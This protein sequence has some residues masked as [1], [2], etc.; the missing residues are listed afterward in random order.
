[1]RLPILDRLDA[2]V[3]RSDGVP[4]FAEEL[5][6]TVAETQAEIAPSGEVPTL[7]IPE[8]LQDSLMA[9]LDALGPVKE[10]AQLCAVLGREFDYP[11][12]LQVSPLTEEALQAALQVALREELFY[13]RGTPPDASYHFRHALIRDA[14]YQSL[15]RSQRQRYHLHIANTMRER[16]PAIVEHQP[17][18]VARHLTEGGD[19]EQAL[20]LWR[21]SGRLAAERSS[22]AEAEA[23]LRA[24]IALLPELSSVPPTL[25]LELY[26]DLAGSVVAVHGLGS[27]EMGAAVR[28]LMELV[29]A[30][31]DSFA[32]NRASAYEVSRGDLAKALDLAQRAQ[33]SAERLGSEA[34]LHQSLNNQSA[35]LVFMSRFAEV[36]ELHRQLRPFDLHAERQRSV[37][38]GT[39]TPLMAG[40]YTA[41][42]L[43]FL[44]R[45]AEAMALSGETV[46][47][48]RELRHPHTL[49]QVAAFA[50]VLRRCLRQF[51]ACVSLAEES[52]HVARENGFPMW[53]GVAGL[54]AAHARTMLGDPQ[55]GAFTEAM[56]GSAR[57][58]NRA[59]ISIILS[60]A[61]EVQRA[62]GDPD[63]ALGLLSLALEQAT[64]LGMLGWHAEL[65]RLRGEIQ[66]TE[67]ADPGAAEASFREALEYARG[68]QARSLELRAATSYARLLREQGRAKEAHALLAPVYEWFTEGHDLPDLLDAKALLD[69]LGA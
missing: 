3:R 36:P 42:A 57:T 58:G 32:L 27:D 15:L 37:E 14:A 49:A 29:E 51:D 31:D 2:I 47:R 26:D 63:A 18:L 41:W 5:T 52:L 16:A 39:G 65:F 44:G 12:L 1:V 48:A 8:T 22:H 10:L 24:A 68:Q 66:A 69:A 6:R 38:I 56:Q 19:A 20:P 43:W 45:P 11:L 53:H 28:R 60:A 50:A 17:E 30:S 61:A 34:R 21:A 13:Q 59:G 46:A 67:L 33:A 25:E 62:A 23:H 7:H 9:R 55:P 64:P 35:P 4:L 54:T 40:I